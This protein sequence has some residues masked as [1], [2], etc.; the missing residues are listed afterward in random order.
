MRFLI[1][2]AVSAHLAADLRRHGHDAV[3][4][5]DCGLTAAIDHCLFVR[6]AEEDRIL[7]SA[8]TGFA[9]VL[10]ARHQPRPSVIL[11]RHAAPRDPQAQRVLLL[12]NLPAIAADLADGCVVVVEADRLRVRAL[13]LAGP[14]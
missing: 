6:A 9:A 8:D 13:P 3:H 14:P 4:A 12:A 10:A 5:R 1:D 2:A 7:V 11:F